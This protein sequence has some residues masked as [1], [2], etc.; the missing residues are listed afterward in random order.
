M[1]PSM[2]S[3]LRKPVV[4]SPPAENGWDL[5]ERVRV[6]DERAFSLLYERHVDAVFGYILTRTKDRTLA[7]EFTSETFLRAFR[8]ID[9]ITYHGSS[10]RAWAFTIARNLILDDVKSARRRHEVV[11]PEGYDEPSDVVDPAAEVCGRAAAVELRRCMEE[12][13]EDQRWC[14]MLRF[15]EH[16]SVQEVANLMRRTEGS[17]RALQWRAVRRLGDFLPRDLFGS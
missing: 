5:V 2:T 12:L 17:V 14:L 3:T 11:M 10:F 9:S 7:E 15:F 8:K 4:P 6:G 13:T 1:S 16:R